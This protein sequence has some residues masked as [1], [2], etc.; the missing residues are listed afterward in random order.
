[1]AGRKN[2]ITQITKKITLIVFNGCNQTLFNQCNQ[3]IPE[4][5]AAKMRKLQNPS[6]QSL[7]SFA[8]DVGIILHYRKIKWKDFK[9]YVGL[10]VELFVTR[11]N[12]YPIYSSLYSIFQIS[13]Y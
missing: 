9:N 6:T 11:S 8:Q 13:N 3:I 10:I 5:F 12:F 1:V 4:I 2:L 7:R